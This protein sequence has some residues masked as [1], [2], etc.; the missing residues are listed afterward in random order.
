VVQKKIYRRSAS[1]ASCWLSQSHDWA[2]ADWIKQLLGRQGP[3]L[4]VTKYRSVSSVVGA[5]YRA[6]IESTE[7]N[8]QQWTNIVEFVR[9]PADIASKFGCEWPVSKGKWEGPK[10]YCSQMEAA[11][12]IIKGIVK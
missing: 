11:S 4:P 8:E 1:D 2:K 12:S 9:K 3:S 7:L 6:K 10:D 5:T